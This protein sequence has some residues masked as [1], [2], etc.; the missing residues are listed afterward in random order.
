MG[1]HV[2]R[3]SKSFEGQGAFLVLQVQVE[4]EKGYLLVD[5]NQR[6]AGVRQAEE[7]PDDL[8]PQGTLVNLLRKYVP[9]GGLGGVYRDRASGD[10]WLPLFTSR[11]DTPHYWLQLCMCAPPEIRFIAPE[12]H[13]SVALARKSSQGSFTKRRPLEESLP[14][15]PMDV[16]RHEDLTQTIWSPAQDEPAEEE[17]KEAAQTFALTAGALPEYQRTARDRLNRRLKTIKKFVNRLGSDTPD[18]AAIAAAEAE[19]A[20]LKTYLWRVKEG[21]LE[22]VTDE[23]PIIALD[24]EATPGHNLDRA[25]TRAKKLRRARDVGLAKAAVGAKEAKEMEVALAKLRGPTLPFIDVEATLRR[26]Q[27]P[28]AKPSAP[29][30]PATAAP[31]AEAWRTYR[32]SVGGATFD[33]LVGKSAKDNDE[34]VKSAASHDLWIHTT[35]VTGSHVVIPARQLRGEEPSLALIKTGAILAIH[36]SKLKGDLAGE[37]YVTR[38]RH[39]RKK[40]G[41]APGLWLVDKAETMFVRYTPPELEAILNAG[42]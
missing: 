22:L 34:L 14:A 28:L 25:F 12:P 37:V 19:A 17:E 3:L 5:A 13:G 27:I 30:G 10:L 15:W 1:P 41:M 6:T 16:T 8:K 42:L 24:P 4:R 18:E 40:K 39:I 32:V 38:R 7:K 9:S 31:V 23:G 2:I 11:A 29:T 26:F 35:G 36:F 21:D 33:L 20:L